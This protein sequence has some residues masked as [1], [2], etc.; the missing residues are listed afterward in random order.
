MTWIW[1]HKYD[2]C[3]FYRSWISRR[4]HTNQ[5]TENLKTLT[6]TRYAYLND[7]LAAAGP[8]LLTWINFIHSMKNDYTNYDIWDEITYPF[9]NLE[10][11]KFGKR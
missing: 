9:P 6:L 3:W 1:V 4:Y 2:G 11:L 10:P 5:I 8:F 7:N